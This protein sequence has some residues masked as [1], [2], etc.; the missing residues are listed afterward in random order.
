MTQFTASFNL[1]TLD[2]S[3][4]FRLDGIAADDRSGVSVSSAGDVNG[5]GYGDVIV[6]TIGADPGGHSFAGESHIVFGKASG[7]AAAMDFSS[8]DGSNG[9]RLD[10]TDASDM[11]GY[12]VSS[13]GDINGDGFD[14]III[15]TYAANKSYVMF[16]KANGFSATADLTSLDGSN[17]FRLNGIDADDRSGHSVSSAGDLNN[18]GFDDIIIGAYGADPN[19]NSSAGESYVVY[20]KAVPF[21]STFDL[22][23]LDGI[24]GFRLDG[25]DAADSSGRP[26]SSAGDV[27]GDGFDDLIIGAKDADPGS[28]KSAGESYVV[29]AVGPVSGEPVE[30][31]SLIGS[32]GFRLDGIDAYDWSGSSVSSAGDINGDGFDDVIIG[33]F[34]ADPG[35]N[36]QAGES[37]VV[38]GKAAGFNASL[39]LASLDGVSGFR[40]NGIDADDGSGRSVSAAGDINGDGYDDIIIGASGADP[41]NNLS[42]GESYVVF[43]K[44]TS[45]AA[46]LDLAGLDG[47]NGFRLNGVNVGDYSGSSVSAAGDVNGDGFD[48]IIIGA[49]GADPGGSRSGA[50]F[51]VFGSKETSAS[52]N[53]VGGP[54]DQT[55]HGGLQNDTISGAGGNDTLFGDAGN[56][57]LNGDDDN[58]ILNGG[59]GDDILNGG[60]G[61]DTADYK[62]AASGV[63]V[64][65]ADTN[66]QNTLGAGR[67]THISIE[68]LTGSAFNDS[69]YGD[70]GDNVL[71]GG[72]GNDRLVAG[73]GN[74]TLYGGDGDDILKGRD[75]NDSLFGGAGSDILYADAGT[76]TLDG[77]TDNDFLYGGRDNDTVNGGDGADRLRGNLGLDVLNGNAGDDMLFGGGQNDVLN[78]GAGV[79]FLLGE[80]GDDTLQGNTGD[81]KAFGGAGVDTFVFDIGDEIL[82]IRDWNIN[83]DQDLI[84]LTDFGFADTAAALDTAVQA[85]DNVKFVLGGGDFIFVENTLLADVEAVDLL[86]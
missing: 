65:L 79:D 30:L 62:D 7:F 57:V 75:G 15:G 20:G 83:G 67:D 17:G 21:A 66:G 60:A 3:N 58:D 76:D 78:G 25:I 41:D 18:D 10:G 74:D 55:M 44:A 63:R 9:F 52:L 34:G 40:V 11:S 33:A 46:T 47:S 8:L 68:N 28:D 24:N 1:S 38:F 73:A 39:D 19:G 45:F 42:A 37:Y 77:G 81:D 32:N 49:W 72:A 48:D 35:G 53:L 50:S 84:D 26:V 22:A 54:G 61:I 85:G 70:A 29:L 82:R 2:G 27:N 36:V 13:A 59:T 71:D 31:S 56:D 4:G 16:G 51:V 12:S 5:D 80:N 14:D 69:L 23:S 64:L 86:I 6:G 43:G